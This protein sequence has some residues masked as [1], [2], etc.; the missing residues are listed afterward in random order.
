VEPSLRLIGDTMEFCAREVP[1]YYPVSVCGYHIRES[2]AGP[3]Q[4]MAYG[5]A[6]AQ[7]YIRQ[8]LERGLGIDEFAHR[9][10]FNFDIFGNLW[11]Q[12]AKFRAGRRLWACLMRGMGAEKAATMKMKMIAG[13][14]GGGL[15]IEEPENNIV[16]GTIYALASALSGAQTMALCCYD[17][18]YT[19]PSEKASLISL[20]TMQILADEMGLTDTVDPLAGSWYIESL[21]SQMEER[22]RE[23]MRRVDEEW[24]GIVNAIAE[25][26]LQRA[27]AQRA[28]LVEKK[29]RTGEMVK[30]GVNKYVTD[31][32]VSQEVAL[33]QHDPAAAEEQRRRLAETKAERNPKAV[34]DALARVR[35][36]ATSGVNLMPSMIEAVRAYCTL[37]EIT[38]VLKEVFG[39]FREPPLF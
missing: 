10:S 20:R 34:Q 14:G 37:G 19:I 28:H 39:R 23:E 32:K 4:E 17:E 18:A 3:A 8:V 29:I 33:H 1:H 38:G 36:D 22:I 12:V 15:T 30:V 13:G 27:V 35:Q 6:I 2:G 9:L 26:H 25:G 5:F 16:R 7:A 11:E 24:G 31:E 21:T